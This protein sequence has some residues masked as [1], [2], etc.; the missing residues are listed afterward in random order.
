MNDCFW[1]AVG[2]CDA[3]TCAGCETYLSINS[4]E[5]EVIH[6]EYEKDIAEAIEPVRERYAEKMKEMGKVR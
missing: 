1:Y 2:T 6:A 4:E 5:C 3:G